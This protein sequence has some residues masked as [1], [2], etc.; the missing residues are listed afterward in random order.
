[1]DIL[2]GNL[3]FKDWDDYRAALAEM[4]SKYPYYPDALKTELAGKMV[5]KLM[6][7]AWPPNPS[8]W[9]ALK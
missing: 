1:V 7:L 4:E 8:L 2:A 3:T 6:G 5:P 9:L